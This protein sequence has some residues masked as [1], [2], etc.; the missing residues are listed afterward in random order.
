MATDH[1]V[2]RERSLTKVC[3]T[4][5]QDAQHRIK[6]CKANSVWVE[7]A[8]LAKTFRGGEFLPAVESFHSA[9]GATLDLV[10]IRRDRKTQQFRLQSFPAFRDCQASRVQ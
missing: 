5:C 9:P 2:Q 1:E 10:V 3:M 7:F 8:L 6:L 4:L